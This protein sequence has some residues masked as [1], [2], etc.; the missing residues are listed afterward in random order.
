MRRFAL[1]LFTLTL[2]LGGLLSCSGDTT[3]VRVTVTFN[4]IQPD[5]VAVTGVVSGIVRFNQKRFPVPARPL[6]SGDD[7]VFRNF[8]DTDDGKVLTLTVQGLQKAVGLASTT[9]KVVISKGSV[10]N[11]TVHLGAKNKDGGLDKGPKLDGLKKDTGK[12]DGKG[13][14]K[15]PLDLK[16]PDKGPVPDKGCTV[17]TKTCNGKNIL[18]CVSSDGGPTL[19]VQKCP[20]GCVPVQCKS[21]LPSN[22]LPT[23]LLG[24]GTKKWQP[25]AKLVTI[26]TTNG[27]FS[28][29]TT[30]P[31]TF[32]KQTAPGPQIMAI[33]FSSIS[34]P[35]GTMVEVVGTNA[36]ALAASGSIEIKGILNGSAKA[37]T[38]G[39]GGGE[40]G[41]YF[42]NA[43]GEGAGG[44][45]CELKTGFSGL[46]TLGG[47]GGGVHAGAAGAGGAGQLSTYTCPGGSPAAAYGKS[48]LEP[49]TGGSGGGRGGTSA[50]NNV[51]EGGG[52]G[53][54]L[55]L[56]SGTEIVIGDG[57]NKVGGINAGGGGGG[58]SGSTYRGGGGG[59]AGG[60]ILLEAPKVTL[61]TGATLAVNGG[62]GG[63]GSGTNFGAT[64]GQPGDM[65]ANPSPG[66]S[67]GTGG[68][69]GGMGAGGSLKSGGLGSTAVAG[70]G[71]GG[72]AGIVRINTLSGTATVN[73]SISGAMTQGSVSVTP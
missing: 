37:T 26:N 57:I 62:G 69:A 58:A 71:G 49:L 67:A 15:M 50:T 45:G 38:P 21:L 53:G 11:V 60:S 35:I 64:A 20:L 40:G 23:N 9:A 66:G 19:V 5:Q 14:D 7:V 54:A 22:G 10:V 55:M 16:Q 43:G 44:K 4:T 52:G 73:G 47:G 36:L 24:S 25:T 12:L 31:H 8:P 41:S 48:K 68:G 39:P 3:G 27:V 59:G 56:I 51:A 65:V 42:A 63:G 29:G 61:H 72:S 46:Y 1:P 18:S 13:P 70:G 34:I 33:A 6:N 30:V 28:D 17:G 2:M 32:V